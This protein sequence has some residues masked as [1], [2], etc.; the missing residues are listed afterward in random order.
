M[1]I[2]EADVR[3]VKQAV[4]IVQL[5]SEYTSLKKS[6]R[7]FAGC[8]P[9]HQERTPSLYVYVEDQG[10]H[11]FGCGAHGDAITLIRE[12]ERLSFVEAVEFLAKRT[13][14]QIERTDT[15]EARRERG[16]RER[17]LAVME[18]AVAFYER[19]LWE[20]PEA[21]PAR[22]YLAGRKLSVEVCRRFRVGWAPG[23]SRMLS[24]ARRAGLAVDDLVLADV[25]LRRDDGSVRDRFFERVAFPICD[26]FGHPIAISARLLPAAERA[27]K[28]AGRGV[29]KYVN[30]TETPLYRK[31]H[32]VFNLHRAR[33]AAGKRL[34]VMEGPTDVMAADQAGLS[35]CAAVLGT[36]LT[37]EH[38]KQLGQLMA[39]RGQVVLLLDGDRAGQANSIRAVGTCLA[40]GVPVHISHLKSGSPR[41][42]DEL[43]TYNHLGDCLLL[44]FDPLLSIPDYRSDLYQATILTIVRQQAH[45][46]TVVTKYPED[47]A[48][49]IRY[50][51]DYCN[52]T[53]LDERKKRQLPPYAIPLQLS[54]A[55][56][57]DIA[58]QLE[59]VQH[60]SHIHIGRI[61]QHGNIWRVSILFPLKQKI[62]PMWWK[63]LKVDILPNYVE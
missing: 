19:T 56:K 1:P 23:G 38:A 9:F 37:G 46:V 13:G 2:S 15:P 62:P 34:I 17:L 58:Q 5:M 42:T 12:K 57:D 49:T 47:W 10:Y 35:E 6:G 26:R 4:D 60:V 14:I 51:S 30:S 40:A 29:G 36:A 16:E 59:T 55:K 24:E 33:Q 63:K 8:C 7:N 61:Q 32:A 3:R 22:E 27:A 20:A 31:S 54:G 44:G 11:C 50:T 39:G 25:A 52:N 41:E 21:A 43:L 28:E 53:L 18:F 45:T 48:A